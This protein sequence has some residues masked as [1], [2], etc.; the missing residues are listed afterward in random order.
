MDENAAPT[1]NAASSTEIP[2][3]P[4][5]AY[6][7]ELLPQSAP[8][9]ESTNAFQACALTVLEDD[10]DYVPQKFNFDFTMERKSFIGK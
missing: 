5:G 3:F 8:V 10:D 2:G 4:E 9:E 1:N 6:W 7:E